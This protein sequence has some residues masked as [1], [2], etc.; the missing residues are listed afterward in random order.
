MD[1]LSASSNNANIKG[2]AKYI[3]KRMQDIQFVGFCHFLADMFTILGRLSLKMQSDA[4][5]LPAAVSQL[6]ETVAENSCLKNCHIPKGH[7]KQFEDV[8]S[9][10]DE[11]GGMEF[12]GIQMEGTLAGK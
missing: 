1:H 8:L 5:I 7:F 4:L 6:N 12:Q 2:R 11:K 9:K 3:A 10:S